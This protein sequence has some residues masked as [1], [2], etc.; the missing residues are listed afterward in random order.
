V[1]R[2][3]FTAAPDHFGAPTARLL[4]SAEQVSEADYRAARAEVEHLLPDAEALLDGLDLL[5]GPAAPYAAPE[6]SPP[7]DTPEG[8]IE[9]I[10]SGP[11]NVTGWPALV[12]PCGLTSEGLPVGLQLAAGRGADGALLGAARV[13]ERLLGS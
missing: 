2:A 13:V 7:I 8:E 6:I 1:A 5:V 9:G 12:L 11:Y 10:Y 3:R 4:R